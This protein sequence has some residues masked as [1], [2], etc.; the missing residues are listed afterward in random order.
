MKTLIPRVLVSLCLAAPFPLLAQNYVDLDFSNHTQATNGS[1]DLGPHY[2]GPVMNF[3]NVAAASGKNID[4]VASVSA[5]SGNYSFVATYPD[6]SSAVK[7]PDGDLGFVYQA[8]GY[9]I[10]GIT[11]TLDFYQGGGSFTDSLAINNFR[12]MMYD[13]DGESW[14]SESVRVYVA[15]GFYGYQL[16]TVGGITVTD[17]GNGSFL[18]TGPGVNRAETDPSAAFILY[19]R[20]TSSINLEM[21][22]DTYERVGRQK[23]PLPNQVFSAIDGDLSM[24]N[25]DMSSFGNITLVPVPEPS[26]LILGL[27]SALPLLRRRR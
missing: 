4:L 25:G 27:L 26:S 21:V 13:V 1:G 6:Y 17:E 11:Y 18:F 24:L 14:Q 9:G 19:F 22:A 3:T 20:N 2:T 5:T 16:P 12:L 15:D 7:Q 8:N 23:G 10:G